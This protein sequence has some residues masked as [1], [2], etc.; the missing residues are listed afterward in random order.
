MTQPKVIAI[1]RLQQDIY[2]K[3]ETKFS[4]IVVTEQ[5]TAFQAGY[6]LGIEAVLKELRNGLT[7]D[8]V[9]VS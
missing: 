7:V 5:T 4:R 3:L 8:D 6:A 9:Q 1:Y 2:K